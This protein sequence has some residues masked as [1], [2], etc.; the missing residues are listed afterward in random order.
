MQGSMIHQWA[1]A[2]LVGVVLT[3]CTATDG[4]DAE[5]AAPPAECLEAAD[6]THDGV[7]ETPVWVRFCPGEERYTAP[8]EVPSDALTTHLDLLDG[9]EERDALGTSAG[10]PC[11]EGSS[12]RTYQLQIGYDDGGV[13]M[14]SGYTD[15]E[16]AGTLSGGGA[17][18][19][20][21][22]LGGTSWP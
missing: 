17:V 20:P 8:A 11:D 9:L 10:R 5:A 7:E 16:C 2:L 1:A 21:D 13:A 22:G 3:A 19:G 12:G 18:G 15:P 4:P 14:I 6:A